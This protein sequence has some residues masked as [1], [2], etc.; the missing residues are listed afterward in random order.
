LSNIVELNDIW[1][2]IDEVISSGGEFTFKPNGISML[3]LIRPGVDTVKLV[4][5]TEVKKSDI[6]LYRRDNGKFVLHRVMYVRRKDF[7]MRGDNQKYLEVGIRR[8][9]ILATLKG[10]EKD[11]VSVDF[12]SEKYKKYVK[13]LYR[14][15]FRYR[16]RA[17]LAGIKHKIFK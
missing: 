11:G 16:L 4:K 17:F 10:I 13:S 6:V 1:H 5:P 14:H 15:I 9:Q 8:D 7:I 3:P 12:A 2:I